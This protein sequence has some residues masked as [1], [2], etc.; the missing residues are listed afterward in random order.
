MHVAAKASPHQIGLTAT[1]ARE[2]ALGV[3]M[4]VHRAFLIAEPL[5]NS[6]L[7]RSCSIPVLVMLVV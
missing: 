1:L 6:A 5:D 3:T 7:S 2:A 4:T